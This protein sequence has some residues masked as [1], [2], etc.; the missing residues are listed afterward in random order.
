MNY[1]V[2]DLNHLEQ[3]VDLRIAY[4][5]EDSGSFSS[6]VEKALR[7][8]LSL[9]FTSHLN[10][11]LFV[12]AAENQGVLVAVSMLL[13]TQK[14]PSP[15]FP[16]GK[17]G[18]VLNVYTHPSY[19]HQG[20]A[21]ELMHRLLKKAIELKLDFVELKSTKPG[22]SLYQ[23]LGFQVEHSPYIPMKYFL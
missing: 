13:L 14:P 6:E 17:I 22:Y 19:R 2:A 5:Q 10:N 18:T 7:K 21:Q 20:L 3:L 23:N 8:E 16:T 15:K 11:D 12:F 1:L 9:Y 4:S